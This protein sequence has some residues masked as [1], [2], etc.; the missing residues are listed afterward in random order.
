[1]N[2]KETEPT[3][4][5]ELELERILQTWR[6]ADN[7]V[8]AMPEIMEWHT[9]AVTEAVEKVLERLRGILDSTL[10]PTDSGY[11]KGFNTLFR[12][13]ETEISAIRSEMK[14]EK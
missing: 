7:V 3:P 8:G 10:E 6:T 12:R 1:M 14:G 2:T 11:E 4:Q 13:V 5:A 9:A